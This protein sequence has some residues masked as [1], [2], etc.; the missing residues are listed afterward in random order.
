MKKTIKQFIKARYDR[1]TFLSMFGAIN[2]GILKSRLKCAGYKRIPKEEKLIEICTE[3]FNHEIRNGI[4]FIACKEQENEWS[5]N[6]NNRKF[7]WKDGELHWMH[8]G[9]SIYSSG[10]SKGNWEDDPKHWA[11]IFTE[12]IEEEL[13]F[14]MKEAKLEFGG[15]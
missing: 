15:N 13:H 11:E 9:E 3:I 1:D 12:E 8:K 5:N 6:I 10:L 4:K 2:I 14:L 7:I